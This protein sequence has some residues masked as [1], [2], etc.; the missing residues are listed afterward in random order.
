MSA[1]RLSDETLEHLKGICEI[2]KFKPGE[3]VTVRGKHSGKMFFVLSGWVDIRFFEKGGGGASLRVGERS[4]L[5]EMGFLSGKKAVATAVAVNV[6]SALELDENTFA[7]LRE[8]S[9][10]AADELSQY[11]AA[12]IDRRLQK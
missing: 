9:S 4:A 3:K 7:T 12:T 2:R 5:G 10:D 1:V 11:L 8:I 6:V